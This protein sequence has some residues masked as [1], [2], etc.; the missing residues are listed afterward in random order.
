MSGD[1]FTTT[2]LDAFGAAIDLNLSRSLDEAAQMALRALLYEHGVLVFRNQTLSNSDQERIMRYF[3]AIL[4]EDGENR[5]IDTTGNLGNCRLL[6]HSDLAFTSE[7]F[8]LLSLYGM[9]VDEGR[10]TTRFASGTRVLDHLPAA[11]RRRLDAL[12]ATTVIP[13]TQTRRAVHYET[14]AFLPQISRPAIIPHAV[15]GK[16]ILYLSE[17]QTSRF[18]QLPPDESAAL[19][20]E[21]F[22]YLYAQENVYEHVWRSGD[23]VIWDNIALA[24]GRPDQTGV[25]RRRLRRI[26]VAD[27]TFFQLCP[28]FQPDDPKVIAWGAGEVLEAAEI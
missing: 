13:P 11:L 8:R 23:L 16:P 24:H 22:G 9:D 18:D 14:P 10:A 20:A 5:E 1:A 26:A 4:G 21:L 17:M 27:K 3:G 7:P 12:T 15:T 19:L 25:A 6:F 2:S 28:Q